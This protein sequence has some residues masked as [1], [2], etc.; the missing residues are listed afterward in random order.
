L[1]QTISTD[2][3]AQTDEVFIYEFDSESVSLSVNGSV[4]LTSDLNQADLIV[5]SIVSATGIAA[6]VG[7]RGG[8]R[9]FVFNGVGDF[10]AALRYL[11]FGIGTLDGKAL[12]FSPDGS[13]VYIA[14]DDQLVRAYT[15]TGV[16]IVAPRWSTAAADSELCDMVVSPSGF[17][18]YVL[19]CASSVV[20]HIQLDETTGEALSTEIYTADSSVA[21]STSGGVF[22]IQALEL[23]VMVGRPDSDEIVVFE[24]NVT[25]G[26]LSSATTVRVT[27]ESEN[28][29]GTVAGFAL[30][31]TERLFVSTADGN[32]GGGV[33]VFN[34]VCP[35]A[36]PSPSPSSAPVVTAA[37]TTPSPSPSP[38]PVVAPTSVPNSLPTVLP[39]TAPELVEARLAAAVHGIDIVFEPGPG[40]LGLWCY[41]NICSETTCSIADL[42]ESGTIALIGTGASCSWRDDITVVVTFGNGNTLAE[43]NTVVLNGGY[44]AGCA[45]CTE[46]ASGSTVVLGRALPPELSSAQFTNTGAQQVTVGF[47]GNPS[48]QEINGTFDAVPCESVFSVASA[49]TLGIRSTCQFFSASSIKVTL[50]AL[51]TI[52]PSSSEVCTDG[53]GT[54]LT[55]LAGVVRTEIGAFL[56]SSAGCVVVDYPANPDRPY[57][58]VS[59]PGVVGFC[60]DLTLEGSATTSPI[61]SANITWEVAL[62]GSDTSADVS[63]VSRV[64]EQASSNKELTVTIPSQYL[65]VHNTFSFVLK[66]DTVLGG[67]S[68][69]AVEVY[70]SSLGLL[71][72]RI[73]GSST[74]QR[75]RGNEIILRSE[76][77]LSSCSTSS[78]DEALASYSWRLVS[79]NESY[80]GAPE[81]EVEVDRDPRVLVIPSHTL[82]FAGS[83]YVFQLR[84]A[85]GNE[86]ITTANATVE[87]L[88][89]PIVA[90]ISGGTK[91][92]IGIWQART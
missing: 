26:V 10:G 29:G 39:S 71:V 7:E 89:G 45:T 35:T 85:F 47:T 79:A 69:A 4:Q 42:L 61:G 19:G 12:A 6:I 84:T 87:I 63:N 82:G 67:S 1:I 33:V 9:R 81:V 53:D 25:N 15:S 46:Y 91:R 17:S 2:K 76:T 18:V 37:P 57:V 83:T 11:N 68:E 72:T 59:A 34:H 50:G 48:S 13:V 24:R 38:A 77:S 28:V 55:L 60:D 90:A 44:V 66:V 73:V 88:S 20:I 51:S 54:S 22:V 74:L 56:T 70:V 16:G 80:E 92:S 49:S 31:S 23:A 3:N 86:T 21:D 43:N 32:G 5:D 64:L 52:T 41:E 8:V 27:S 62:A 58:E 30:G 78:A 65:S 14:S 75:T 36:A 40:G